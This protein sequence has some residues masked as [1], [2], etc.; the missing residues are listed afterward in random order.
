VDRCQTDRIIPARFMPTTTLN[1]NI[2]MI[3]IES[4]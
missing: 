4:I 2:C 3:M 1:K